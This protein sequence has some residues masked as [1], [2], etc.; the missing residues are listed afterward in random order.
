MKVKCILFLDVFGQRVETSPWLTLGHIYHVVGI[1]VQPDGKTSYHIVT[2]DQPGEWPSMGY[3][4]SRCFKV[5]SSIAPSNWRV[6]LNQGSISIEPD[7]WQARGFLEA[8]HDHD[9]STLPVFDR[10]RAV[11]LAEDA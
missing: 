8:F 2:H 1:N 3:Y 4:D 11:I 9:P 6:S 10:E 7:A 5:M